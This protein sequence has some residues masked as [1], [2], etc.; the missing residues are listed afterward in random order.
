KRKY[1]V[2]QFMLLLVVLVVGCGQ[3]QQDGQ[4]QS[5]GQDQQAEQTQQRPATR[6]AT[7]AATPLQSNHAQLTLSSL[8]ASAVTEEGW[9]VVTN[10]NVALIKDGDVDIPAQEAGVLM[11]FHVRE[12]SVVEAEADLAQ[13][14]DADAQV[15]LKSA[16]LELSVAKKE[17]KNDINVKA[18]KAA[19]AVADAELKQSLEVNKNAPG[20]I[21]ETQIEREKLT[22]TRAKLQIEVAELEFEVAQLTS[23]VRQAQV[24]V[25][26]LSVNRR[27][28]KSPIAGVVEQRYKDVGEWVQPGEPIMQVI[29]LDQ[30]RIEGFLRADEV[31]PTD[32]VNKD[33][34][35]EVIFKK[36]AEDAGN[37]LLEPFAGKLTFVSNQVQAGGEYKVW[38]E[39]KN[40]QTPDGQWVL[41]PGMVATMKIKLAD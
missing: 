26:G 25:G 32:V 9:I 15:R 35:V 10:C 8:P 5:P 14:D 1:A 27:Q 13:I 17:A 40:R 16:E 29:R 34:S 36:S 7:P 18:A 4:N 20:A 12:G 33:V 6:A 28:V 38:A 23:E 21:P 37:Q 41:R 31:L 3:D 22:K 24:D 19:Y 11:K 39:V 30:L 2:R